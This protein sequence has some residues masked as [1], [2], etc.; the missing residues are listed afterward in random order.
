MLALGEKIGKQT[1]HEVVYEI[2]MSSFEKEIPFKEA[3]MSDQRVSNHLKEE[4]SWNINPEAYIGESE[5]I[6]DKVLEKSN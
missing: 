1:A 5:E 2:A 3:L 4:E 6:V